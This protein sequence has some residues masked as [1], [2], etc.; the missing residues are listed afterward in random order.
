MNKN[1]FVSMRTQWLQMASADL[2]EKI[3][4]FM[5]QNGM[6]EAQLAD[7]LALNVSDVR[8]MLNNSGELSLKAFA[9]LLIATGNVIEIKP[10]NAAMMHGMGRAPQPTM[11]GRRGVASPKPNTPKRDAHGRFVPKGMM[12]PMPMSPDGRPMPMPMGGMPMG[13]PGQ[14]YPTPQNMSDMFGGMPMPPQFSQ[15]HQQQPQSAPVAPQHQPV[16]SVFDSM[17]REQLVDEVLK[18]NWE[19]EIDMV[20]ANRSQII[21]FLESKQQPQQQQSVQTEQPTQNGNISE[22]AQMIANELQSNPQ[23]LQK[24]AQSFGH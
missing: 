5:E 22:F 7:A 9:S 15:H 16:G 3:I 18:H 24:L 14:P 8:N 13:A 20:R 4:T 17:S 11:G 23:L 10:F 12:P 21:A 6:N 2:N 19:S 1:E